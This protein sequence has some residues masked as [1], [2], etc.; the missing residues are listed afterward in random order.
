MKPRNLKEG[1]EKAVFRDELEGRVGNQ[2]FG[3]SAKL[4]VKRAEGEGLGVP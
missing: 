1:G 2:S 4:R 3:S